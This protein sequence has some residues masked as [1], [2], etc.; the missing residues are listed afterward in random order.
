MCQDVR[1]AQVFLWDV[2]WQRNEG[3]GDR[4][5]EF[6]GVQ[7]MGLPDVFL[8]CMN[9]WSL[10]VDTCTPEGRLQS[11]WCCR[12]RHECNHET[13]WAECEHCGVKASVGNAEKSHS[14]PDVPAL[15][16]CAST[17]WLTEQRWF[18]ASIIVQINT[19]SDHHG[20][21]QVSWYLTPRSLGS[22]GWD[23]RI[24]FRKVNCID[25]EKMLI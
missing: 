6:G 1:N 16:L 18:Q 19:W 17:S 20:A 21:S 13:F 14:G 7:P 3:K 15:Q 24:H 2:R 5:G 22:I 8:M 23:Y 4:E 11:V 12:Y 25:W 9:D 10:Y